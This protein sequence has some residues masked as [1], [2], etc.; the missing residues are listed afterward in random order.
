MDNDSELLLVD[1]K[2]DTSLSEKDGVGICLARGESKT[3]NQRLMEDTYDEEQ[4]PA[5][6]T[7]GG[8]TPAFEEIFNGIS[9]EDVIDAICY[10]VENDLIDET[11]ELTCGIVSTLNNIGVMDLLEEPLYISVEYVLDDENK[12]VINLGTNLPEI[13]EDLDVDYYRILTMLDGIFTAYG[14]YYGQASC[15]KWQDYVNFGFH[16]PKAFRE[17]VYSLFRK[18]L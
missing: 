9:D 7:I 3:L 12:L 1:W 5:S 10:E 6:E 14:S 17:V 18:F 15:T 8:W 13:I 16:D 11:Q 2:N 4:Y